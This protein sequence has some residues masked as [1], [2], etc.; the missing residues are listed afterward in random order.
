MNNPGDSLS[1]KTPMSSSSCHEPVSNRYTPS[2]PPFD[3][4]SPTS[5]GG[6]V[7]D[8]VQDRFWDCAGQRYRGTRNYRTSRGS[9]A[10]RKSARN[11]CGILITA[12]LHTQSS[13]YIWACLTCWLKLECRRSLSARCSALTRSHLNP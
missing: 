7:F 12:H 5:M 4:P 6:T 13:Q 1:L 3:K 9:G 10:R 11:F 8:L 2:L